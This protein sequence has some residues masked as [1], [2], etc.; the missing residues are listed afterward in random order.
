MSNRR[1][2]T[3]FTAAAIALGSLAVT[4][5]GAFAAAP[6]PPHYKPLICAFLPFL[7]PAPMAK[8]KPVHHHKSHMMKT[9]KPKAPAK[10]KY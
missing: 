9:S 7:C 2:L 8:P 6:P 10:P 1:L 4:A 5:D 3:T